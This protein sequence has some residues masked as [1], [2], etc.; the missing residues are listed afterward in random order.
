MVR[1]E[2]EGIDIVIDR[3]VDINEGIGKFWSGAEGWAP[4]EAAKLLS[5][6][7]LDWQISL[8][9]SLKIWF[10]N[11]NFNPDEES[12]RLIL[13]WANL[14]CL[15]E[16]TLKLFLSIYYKDYLN[17]VHVIKKEKNKLVIVK[18]LDE[19]ML[20]DLR[21]F[22]FKKERVETILDKKW[23]EWI[24]LIQ[25]RRNA[26]HAYR[27]RDIGNFKEFSKNV[28]N[29]LVFLEDINGRLPYPDDV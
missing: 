21:K 7:R 13:A 18:E 20:G 16:G 1:T 4:I 9:K 22:L 3:I 8:S 19:L 12:G 24:E 29:Y 28:R 14:G 5:K 15:V 27:D 11:S 25:R 26:I 23:D 6:S 10:D 2:I 17:D